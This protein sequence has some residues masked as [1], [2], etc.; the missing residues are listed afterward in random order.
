MLLLRDFNA[1]TGN[2]E[3]EIINGEPQKSR[4]GALLRDEIKHFNLEI[5]DNKATEEKWT[6]INS[7]IINE[8]SIVD[9]IICNNKLTKHIADVI[10]DQKQDFLLIGK[11]KIDHNI[12]FLKIAAE[13]KN[14]NKEKI[15]IW[16]INE[17]TNWKTYEN[18]IK[19]ELKNK[20]K[21]TL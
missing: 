14:S 18:V 17:K 20:K 8:K 3:L 16:K 10:I 11:K 15:K 21:K 1:K 6:R 4:N 19:E 2:E 13:P 12:I 5:L 7:N 9:Y